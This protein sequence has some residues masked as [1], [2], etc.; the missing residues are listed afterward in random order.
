MIYVYID[1]INS[2][3]TY[4]CTQHFQNR[5]AYSFISENK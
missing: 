2:L 3:E 4:V 5:V 1:S